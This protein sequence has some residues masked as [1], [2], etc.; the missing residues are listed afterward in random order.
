MFRGKTKINKSVST[1]SIRVCLNM[2]VKGYIKLLSVFMFIVICMIYYTFSGIYNLT[3]TSVHYTRRYTITSDIDIAILI[4][5][6]TR[7]MKSPKLEK[8]SLMRFCLPSIVATMESVYNYTVYIG[9]DKGD[10]LRTVEAKILH[11]FP[12]VKSVHVEGGTFTKAV[13]QIA[14]VAYNDSMTYFVRI[15][16]DT[17]FVTKYW[18]S[19][20]IQTLRN[21]VPSNVGVVGPNCKHGNQHILTHDMVHRTHLDIF[22]YY[23]P[24]EFENWWADNWITNVYKPNRSTK[25]KTWAVHH[26]MIHGTRYAINVATSKRLLK[27]SSIDKR[28]LDRYIGFMSTNSTHDI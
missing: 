4:P 5:T 17:E 7:T 22:H 20:G 12:F 23:Y 27:I 24:P 13:N 8:L 14:K 19:A 6:T 1:H 2:M 10:Y 28:I 26:K 18:A 9:I 21:Y 11:K 3:G 15:N 16:D 25:S